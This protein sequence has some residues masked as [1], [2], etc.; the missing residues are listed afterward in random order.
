MRTGLGSYQ[1]V[2]ALALM[3]AASMAAAQVPVLEVEPNNAPSTAQL[4]SPALYPTGAVAIDGL[5]APDGALNGVDFFAFDL[6][7]G[8]FVAVSVFDDT[9]AIDDDNDPLLGIFDPSGILFDSDDDSGP[10][11]LP[12][13]SFVVPT[14]GRWAFAVTGFGDDPTYNGS[15]QET[16][17]YK[18]VF[19][20][21]PVPTPG[22]AAL[23]AIAGAA[24]LRRRR[25]AA[26]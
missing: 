4:V 13:F 8:D 1:F 3:G 22:A 2:P 5:I 26:R 15:H 7:A 17:N 11:L 23:G 21:N 6:L 25:P 10:G 18:F 24:L 19:A 16:F 14:S 12:S 9:P 20:I